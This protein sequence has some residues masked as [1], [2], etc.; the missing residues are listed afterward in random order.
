MAP[1]QHVVHG[2]LSSG[3]L[4]IRATYLQMEEEEPTHSSSAVDGQ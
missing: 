2:G 4:G 1:M 3:D